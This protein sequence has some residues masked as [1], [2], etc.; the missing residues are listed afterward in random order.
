MQYVT[1]SH[2]RNNEKKSNDRKAIYM[3]VRITILL[4]ALLILT[5]YLCVLLAGTTGKIAGKITDAATGETLVSANI[6]VKGTSLGTISD[7]DGNY[8]ILNIPPGVYSM[9]V[10]IIGYQ[11]IQFDN[12]SVSVDLTTLIDAALQVKAVELESIIVTAERPMVIKDMTGSLATTTAEQIQNLPVQSVQQVLRLTAGVIESDGRLYIRGGRA[13]EVGYWVDGISA[14]DLYDGRMGVS[15]EN[16]AVQ[17]MQ[18]I[19]GTFNAEY[20][21][22]MSGIVNVVT[23]E[24]G[25]KYSG[26]IKVYAGDYLSNREEYALYKKL[27]TAE[28]RNHPIGDGYGTKIISSEKDNPLKKINPIY[29]GEFSVS[30]PVPL[31]GNSLTFFANGRYFHDEGYFY[32]VNWF[33]PSGA[34]GDSSLVALNPNETKS[35]LGKLNYQFSGSIKLGYNIYWNTSKRDRNYFRTNSIDY[36]FNPTGAANFTQFNVHDYKYNPYGLPKYF[37]EGFTHTFT[38]NHIL[39]NSTFYELRVSRYTSESKQYVY[40]NPTASVNY[41]VRVEED[42]T[43]GIVAEEFDPYT[44]SGQA[45]LQ[46]IQALGGRYSYIAAPNTP[47]GYIDPQTIGATAVASFLDKGMDPTR[48]KRTTAYWVGK[49]DLTSQL[50]KTHQLKFG[51]EV[52]LYELTLHSY[53]IVAKTDAY[54]S[55]LDPFQPA[56][57]VVGNIYRNDYNRKPKEISAYLQDKIEFNDIILNVGLRFDYFDANS[58]IPTDP[59]DPDIYGYGS[60]EG[61]FKDEHKYKDLNGNGVIGDTVNGIY[62]RDESNEYTPKERRA[63]MQKKV[64]S[65]IS[66]SPRLGISFPITDR[67]VIHLSYGHF[68]QVPEFQYLYTNPDFKVSS[69]SGTA[70]FGNAALRPQKTV[71]YEIGLQQQITDVIGIDVTLFYRDIRDWVG[72]SPII[73]TVKEG[74]SYSQFVNKDYENVRGITLRFDK[75]YADNFSFRADYT[76][77]SAEGTYSNPQDAYNSALAN[78]APMLILVP[79]NWDQ[80]HTVNAQFIYDIS[81]WTF[82]LIGRYWSGRPYTPSFPQAEA[83]GASA[84]TTALTTNSARRPDQKS[85]DLTINRKFNLISG[86]TLELFVNVYNLLDQNDATTVFTDT[87]SPEYT[88]NSNRNPAKIT[89]NSSRISTAEDY[90][91]E[92]SWYTAPRQIQIGFTV[93]F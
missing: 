62:E 1:N 40:D 53:R 37:G 36:Q 7:I 33:R 91:I 48:T 22:A 10:T 82:S 24:G 67:G 4:I 75:R 60:T 88:T 59:T 77:Q 34:C 17:E 11:Q 30:G 42:A 78:R 29:N 19:S 23:K 80:K 52:R 61:P 39:S 68:S 45:K 47:D 76:F 86:L 87:G 6:I 55:P 18:V 31:L 46:S 44:T 73:K 85:I 50:N 41:W 72:T 14:T 71:Q 8:S 56:I 25:S 54:G 21:Q 5:A 38:L 35:L 16:S 32:G 3:K 90:L 28:D 69:G 20:G 13:G 65:K 51:S 63:F 70:L 15:I 66:L 93:G 9:S 12:V 27:V 64:N 83:V 26:Q 79:M 92:P 49:F 58:V 89:Y 84:N 81:N 43:K 2:R 57:P 74:V